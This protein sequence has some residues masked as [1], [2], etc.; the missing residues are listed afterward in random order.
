MKGKIM[1]KVIIIIA[2]IATL[3]GVFIIS[4]T[5][6]GKEINGIVDHRERTILA[7]TR[8][9]NDWMEVSKY[10]CVIGD[11]YVYDGI[12]AYCGSGNTEEKVFNSTWELIS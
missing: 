3:I 1:K 6:S 9:E 8:D 7:I 4:N 2:I 11:R 12:V 5:V 10:S